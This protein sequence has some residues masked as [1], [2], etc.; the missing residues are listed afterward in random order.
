MTRIQYQFLKNNKSE[1]RIILVAFVM[2]MLFLL[3]GEV[4]S[5]IYTDTFISF[6]SYFIPF[7]ILSII[8]LLVAAERYYFILKNNKKSFWHLVIAVVITPFIMFIMS[9]VLYGFVWMLLAVIGSIL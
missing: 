1:H 3:A 6:S 5:S 4:L 7:L 2:A 8:A 9:A